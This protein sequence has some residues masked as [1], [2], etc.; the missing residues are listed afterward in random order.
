MSRE[1]KPATSDVLMKEK[2]CEKMS[3]DVKFKLILKFF[4]VFFNVS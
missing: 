1:N 4:F 2:N 3:R